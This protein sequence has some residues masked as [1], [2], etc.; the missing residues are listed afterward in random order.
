MKILWESNQTLHWASRVEMEHRKKKWKRI[1][2]KCAF[3]VQMREIK[4]Y[5][6]KFL[7]RTIAL[8][9]L[10]ATNPNLIYCAF[11][12][13]DERIKMN[14]HWICSDNFSFSS[15]DLNERKR[16]KMT[17]K[18]IYLLKKTFIVQWNIVTYLLLIIILRVYYSHR[19]WNNIINT[20]RTRTELTMLHNINNFIIIIIVNT[21]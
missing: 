11:W 6:I 4:K 15:A 16:L 9:H 8:L 17:Q 1:T 14:N 20:P 12:S 7:P 21:H 18:I 3:R 5:K 19:S 13:W 10:L 2:K